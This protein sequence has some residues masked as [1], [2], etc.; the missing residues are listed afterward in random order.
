ML[1]LPR[2][3]SAARGSDD[4]DNLLVGA[5]ELEYF[6][7]PAPSRARHSADKANIDSISH[8]HESRMK[9][10]EQRDA[11]MNIIAVSSV[12]C[13]APPINPQICQGLL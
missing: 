9:V 13:F 5:T 3:G 4:A 2:Q 7:V 6:R 10:G 8:P 12:G 11:I 1:K